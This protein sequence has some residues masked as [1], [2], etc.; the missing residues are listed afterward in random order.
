MEQ[1]YVDELVNG[2]VNIYGKSLESIILYGS[3]ARGTSTEESDID[4]AILIHGQMDDILKDKLV[5]FAVDMDLKYEKVFSIVDIEY[6]NFVKWEKVM[7]FYRNV[8]E[9][10]IVLW[11]T[12]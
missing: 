7:P 2:L 3:V 11:K 6:S 5:D 12:A 10:G 9:E 1:K 4:I 8:K